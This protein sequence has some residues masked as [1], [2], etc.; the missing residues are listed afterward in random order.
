M[1]IEAQLMTISGWGNF[2][3]TKATV[4]QPDTEGE[5]KTILEKEGI[6]LARGNAKSYGDASLAG[7]V[8]DMRKMKKML[9]FDCEKGIF[10]AEAGILL[11]EI[12]EIIVPKGW[13][14]PVTPG[15][16]LITFGG[17]IASDVHGKNHHHQGCL[18]NHLTWIEL[19]TDQGIVIRA[20]RKEN[21]DWYW[22]TCGGLGL[23]GIILRAGIQLMPIRSAFLEVRTIHTPNLDALLLEFDK[24]QASEYFAGWIDCFASGTSLGKG[25]LFCADHLEQGDSVPA[26]N[27]W[28]PAP[29]ARKIPRWM[30][31][32][33]WLYAPAMRVYNINYRRTS[34]PGRKIQDFDTY[35]YPL[36]ALENWNLLYGP[37]GFV[38]F[39][40][41]IPLET[42]RK[43]L[44]EILSI[45][46]SGPD[47]PYLAVIK[48]HGPRP[49]EAKNAFPDK[50]YSLALDF[51][52]SSTIAATF[53]KLEVVLKAVQGK[54]YLTKDAIGDPA[55]AGLDWSQFTSKKFVSHLKNRLSAGRSHA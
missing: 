32:V 6:V 18:S 15:I 28:K 46:S 25:I 14:L 43:A 38:Q 5:I 21:A 4:Y 22:K 11:S 34:S 42:S 29:V 35:F 1:S 27:E 30:G 12:L 13:F 16:K 40:C 10:E 55:L 8:I 51:P 54:Y 48:R 17:A 52:R 47:K 2:P 36:D 23:S 37:A 26:L 24:N 39:Q 41:L 53:R 3:K 9:R 49:P 19:M 44:R 20:S 7:A 33:R 50:G 45:A 31:K